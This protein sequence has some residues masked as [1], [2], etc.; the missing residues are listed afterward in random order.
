M[1]RS[2]SPG[3]IVVDGG[4]LGLEVVGDALVGPGVLRGGCF[5][6]VSPQRFVEGFDEEAPRGGPECGVEVT[7]IQGLPGEFVG[8]GE[9]GIGHRVHRGVGSAVAGSAVEFEPGVGAHR[10][11]H[12]P[13]RPPVKT[14]C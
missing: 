3:E 14:I 8:V 7:G 4:D 9:D 6:T 1:H 13:F 11:V 5:W 10:R 2:F 12:G